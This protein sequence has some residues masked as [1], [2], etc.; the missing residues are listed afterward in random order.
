MDQLPLT[1]GNLLMQCHNH[2]YYENYHKYN[3]E[4]LDLFYFSSCKSYKFYKY[5]WK[6]MFWLFKLWTIYSCLY[7]WLPTAQN[8]QA[9][10]KTNILLCTRII[11]WKHNTSMADIKSFWSILKTE[12]WKSYLLCKRWVILKMNRIPYQLLTYFFN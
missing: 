10:C 8:N 3:T 2:T 11:T 9:R 7:Y 4:L 5:Y 12:N 6:D 1:H